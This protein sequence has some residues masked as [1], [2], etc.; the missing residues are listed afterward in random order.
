M[1]NFHKND[2]Y[3]N[4]KQNPNV[5]SQEVDVEIESVDRDHFPQEITF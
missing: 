3:W 4:E 5:G 1:D 2:F